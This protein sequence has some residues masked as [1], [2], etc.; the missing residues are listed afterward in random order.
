MTDA[1]VLVRIRDAFA[2][3]ERPARFT[4]RDHCC[5]C[6]E[7]DDV[8]R[9][10]DLDGLTIDDVGNPGWDPICFAT[11]DAFL[12]LF[13]ALARL[14][15]EGPKQGSGWYLEQLL[16]HLTYEGSSNRRLLAAAPRQRAAVVLLLHHVRTTRPTAIAEH[17]LGTALQE[18]LVLWGAGAAADVAP[19]TFPGRTVPSHRGGPR[20]GGPTDA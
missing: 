8:L 6:A 16:F 11:N 12:Y 2:A 13:P 1:D 19:D 18:A 10:R 15:L 5:E 4:N 14:A 9:A 17:L 20:R 7:H 3:A